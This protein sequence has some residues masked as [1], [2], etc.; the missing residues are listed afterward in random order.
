VRAFYPSAEIVLS[1]TGEVKE[2]C[3]ACTHDFFRKARAL[4]ITYGHA[5]LDGIMKAT[6]H[7]NNI[8]YTSVDSIRRKESQALPGVLCMHSHP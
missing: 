3:L 1:V 6:I 5:R 8:R 7:E 2:N 4:E